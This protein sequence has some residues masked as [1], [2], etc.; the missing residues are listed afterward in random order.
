MNFKLNDDQLGD[1]MIQTK[2][3]EDNPLKGAE[4]WIE[5]NQDVVDEWMK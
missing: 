2:E 4:K 3:N 5:E 1:L